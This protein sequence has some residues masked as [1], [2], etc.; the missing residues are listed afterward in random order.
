MP[1]DESLAAFLEQWASMVGIPMA[2]E[3]VDTAGSVPSLT[4]KQMSRRLQR[5]AGIADVES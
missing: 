4:R 2:A 1:V 3:G 5:H